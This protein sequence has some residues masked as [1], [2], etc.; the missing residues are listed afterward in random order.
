M[1]MKKLISFLCAAA[2]TVSSFAG[3]AVTASA[4]ADTVAITPT[5]GSKTV[6]VKKEGTTVTQGVLLHAVYA[7]GALTSVE[8]Q[9]IPATASAD[10]DV[11]YTKAA[12]AEYTSGTGS[13]FLAWKSLEGMEPITVNIVEPPAPKTQVNTVA[14]VAITRAQDDTYPATLTATVT[15]KQDA[16]FTDTTSFTYS[17]SKDGVAVNGGENGTLTA[18]TAGS[19]TVTATYNNSEGDFEG[20]ITSAPFSVED[21]TDTR[22]S[23]A[24][25]VTVT[26]T[27][28]ENNT[29]TPTTLTATVADVQDIATPT[30]L[31]ADDFTY[32]WTKDGETVD[33]ATTKTLEVAAGGA[34]EYKVVATVKSDNATYKGSTPQS[35][36]ITIKEPIV[37]DPYVSGTAPE[38]A[39]IRAVSVNVDDDSKA[40]T[41]K[42]LVEGEV[43]TT[44][45]TKDGADHNETYVKGALL[46]QKNS[47]GE[48]P[49]IVR[50]DK[51]DLDLT[52][53]KAY[54]KFTAKT[55][56][57]SSNL[58]L[59]TATAPSTDDIAALTGETKLATGTQLKKWGNTANTTDEVEITSLFDNDT[60]VVWFVINSESVRI[61][62]ITNLEFVVKAPHNVTVD[63]NITGGTITPDKATALQGETVTLTVTP[64]TGKEL[65]ADSLKVNN[66]AV[67]VEAVGVD[68]RFTM[69]DADATI[70]ATF[71]DET[72]PKYAVTLTGVPGY[73][74]VYTSTDGETYTTNPVART[75]HLGQIIQ[76]GDGTAAPSAVDATD[77]LIAR[78]PNGS[79]V[80]YKI[81][82][83]GYP[84]KTG[85]VTPN[86][87]AVAIDASSMAPTAAGV[88]YSENGD[89]NNANNASTM[90]GGTCRGDTARIRW[91]NSGA[92][93]TLN[94]D[95]L[96]ADKYALDFTISG[97]GTWQ[98]K[99]TT[100]TFKD[101]ADKTLATIKF[102]CTS[103][104]SS[105][106]WGKAQSAVLTVGSNSTTVTPSGSDT[107]FNAAKAIKLTVDKTTGTVTFKYGDDSV[108][109]TVD[110]AGMIKNIAMGGNNLQ[111]VTNLITVSTYTPVTPAA[112]TI[113]F[114]ASN[115]W[116]VKKGSSAIDSGAT[117]A[118][119][120]VITIEATAADKKVKSVTATGATFTVT[121]GV[122]SA[123]V[124]ATPADIVITAVELEDKTPATQATT[125]TITAVGADTDLNGKKLADL[126][127]SFTITGT[128]KAYTAKGTLKYVTGYTG[129][130]SNVAEQ[131]GNYLPFV[132]NVDDYN[133]NS[134]IKIKGN[135]AG[136]TE[137]TYTYADCNDGVFVFILGGQSTSLS[138]KVDRDGSGTAY[139]ETEYTLSWT[140]ATTA[141]EADKL[142]F[143]PATPTLSGTVTVKVDGEAAA[144]ATT[145]DT[146]T[147]DVTGVTASSGTPTLKYQW[148]KFNTAA[149]E[150]TITVGSFTGAWEDVDGKTAATYATPEVGIYRVVVSAD[151]YDGTVASGAVTVTQSMYRTY[152]FRTANNGYIDESNSYKT[153]NAELEQTRGSKDGQ[154]YDINGNG[155]V[156]FD[157]GSY[158]DNS[159]GVVVWGGENKITITAEGP[160]KITVGGC[161]Y[162]AATKVTLKAD[163]T[164]VDN[165][166]YLTDDS[167]P[168]A[169]TCWTGTDSETNSYVLKYAGSEAAT[170]TIV[171]DNYVYLPMLRIE[172]VTMV[173]V[174]AENASVAV[175]P[176]A[177]YTAGTALT[178]TATGTAETAAAEL[179][180]D[181]FDYKW[182]AGA[183]ATGTAL[184]E[185]AA[186][187]PTAAGKYT[188]EATANKFG[189]TGS[190]TTTVDV[191]AAPSKTDVTATVALSSTGDVVTATLS[192][193]DPAAAEGSFTYAWKKS[194]DNGT[195]W[196]D[197]EDVTSASITN[198]E[199]KAQYKVTASIPAGNET[200]AGS[201][202]S[203]AYTLDLT[204]S[205]KASETDLK[206]TAGHY[207]M[208]GL[209]TLFTDDA[210]KDLSATIEEENFT[211]YITCGTNGSWS[212][213]KAE[214]TALKYVAA[215]NGTFKIYVVNLNS[216]KELLITK[217]GTA[218][219]D[220]KTNTAGV[221]AYYKNEG[222][223]GSATLSLDVTKGETYYAYVAG[224]KANFV[225][226]KLD[227]DKYAVK[228]INPNDGEATPTDTA[229]ITLTDGVTN[230]LAAKDGKVTLTAVPVD[231]KA[232]TAVTV[233]KASGGTVEV[234]KEATAN[235]YSFTMPAEPV[236]VTATVA[237]TSA[238]APASITVSGAASVDANSTSTYTAAVYDAEGKVTSENGVT[239]TVY[240]DAGATTP[241]DKSEISDEGVLSV[242][243]DETAEALYIVATS[244]VSGS[245]GVK[246][247]AKAVT[248]NSV[249]VKQLVSFSRVT[250]EG[251]AVTSGYV[252]AAEDEAP[253]TGF[254][255]TAVTTI[256]AAQTGAAKLAAA[257]ADGKAELYLNPNKTY[258]LTLKTAEDGDVIATNIAYAPTVAAETTAVNKAVAAASVPEKDALTAAG[259]TSITP[260]NAIVGDEVT[261]TIPA[262]DTGVTI[263]GVKVNGTIDAEKVTDTTYKVTIPAGGI[264]DIVISKT[265]Q[266]YATISTF[267]DE[268]LGKQQSD[269]NSGL[270][271]TLDAEKANTYN[272]TGTLKYVS[273]WTEFD[274]KNTELQSG[275][276]IS[277]QVVIP[278][279]TA[280]STISV[281]GNAQGSTPINV[282]KASEDFVIHLGSQSTALIVTVDKDGA[283]G[284]N[285][286][287][288]EYTIDI[289]KLVKNP[290]P[291]ASSATVTTSTSETPWKGHSPNELGT[292]TVQST[293]QEGYDYELVGTANYIADY[294][295]AFGTEDG[296][297][298][299]KGYYIPFSIDIPSTVADP[300][301]AVLTYKSSAATKTYTYDSFTTEDRN[302]TV[303]L[304]LNP[305]ATYFTYTIDWDG[306]GEAFTAK[307]YK[308]YIDQSGTS[309]ETETKL[310]KAPQPVTNYTITLPTGLTGGSVAVTT[311]DNYNATTGVAEGTDVVITA[312]PSEGYQLKT[313]TV[314]NGDETVTDT[315]SDNTTYTFTMPAGNVSVSAEFEQLFAITKSAMTN[316]GV[317]VY[318]VTENSGT[319]TKA[320]AEIADLTKVADGTKI[321]VEANPDDGYALSGDI[322]VV[323]T[324]TASD[325]TPTAATSETL[326]VS[327]VADTTVYTV[328]AALTISAA[329]EWNVLD[330]DY[331]AYSTAAITTTTANGQDIAVA[332][333]DKWK[334]VSH[335]SAFPSWQ[336][337]EG[338]GVIFKA[339]SAN[340]KSRPYTVKKAFSDTINTGKV[341]VHAEGGIANW[342][343]GET[344]TGNRGNF[345]G[346]VDS[347]GKDVI[348]IGFNRSGVQTYLNGVW[349]SY[350]GTKENLDLGSMTIDLTVDFDLG[351][352]TYRVYNVGK[353]ATALEGSISIDKTTANAA[354]IVL[355][356]LGILED[357][358]T[359]TV[360]ELKAMHQTPETTATT[361][362]IKSVDNG[363]S[364][365]VLGE[366][367]NQAGY[368]GEWIRID[369]A[370]KTFNSKKYKY[371][372]DDSATK[373]L[374]S[375]A[376][377]N[378]ITIKYNPYST[379]TFTATLNSAA[380]SGVPIVISTADE[381]EQGA[382]QTYTT[383]DTITTGADGTASKELLAG[384][385]YYSI[386][387][388]TD[389]EAVANAESTKVIVSN[390][391]T[392]V[393]VAVALAEK[394]DPTYNVTI[395]T[396]PYAT[397][398]IGALTTPKGTEVAAKTKKADRKGVVKF[399]S[400]DMLPAASYTVTLTSDNGYFAAKANQTMT[401]TSEATTF[402]YPFEYDT[403]TYPNLIY[404]ED[405][406]Y[407][408]KTE[409]V[410]F[411]E[412]A[413]I[414]SLTN[415]NYS[416]IYASA[417]GASGYG[418]NVTQIA[419]NNN[420][421]YY[422]AGYNSDNHEVKFNPNQ[423]I[424]KATFDYAIGAQTWAGG[425][426]SARG[427]AAQTLEFGNLIITLTPASTSAQSDTT[428]G[429]D[430]TI[431]IT[432]GTT[433][434][435]ATSKVKQLAWAKYSI[436]VA[437]DKSVTV[438]VTPRGG[439]V[440]SI[441]GFT[442]TKDVTAFSFKG[443]RSASFAIDN[444]E[445][446]GAAE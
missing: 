161:Q 256:P 428:L 14:D 245:E 214:G 278:E 345:F 227:V 215:A 274:G 231:G 101:A 303:I 198:A 260:A 237:S 403:T 136:S 376:E 116:T 194:T 52:G 167:T 118:A 140:K 65:Q 251:S 13:K 289:S 178:A 95:S 446:Y 325:Q 272:A 117:L 442:L 281:V 240:T 439:T 262:A 217:A 242:G 53:K 91:Q 250:D 2:L 348:T 124:G 103:Y 7:N 30:G 386:A 253:N 158:Y 394:G 313:L 129:F 148:Q 444:I 329:F 212:E 437:G 324:A 28:A 284:T 113:T 435:S 64:A 368:V 292:F 220:I 332:T 102:A 426:P 81:T 43:K 163:G 59:S 72:T 347:A 73:A 243:A 261:I 96:T 160:T 184:A 309:A 82:K 216:Q 23:V 69:P 218:T 108:S 4:A 110:G 362:T 283:E 391:G 155:T 264:N 267:A 196:T 174:N 122:A 27:A 47:K 15:A 238:G 153:D 169:G 305:A 11:T 55:N 392:A 326:T 70:T 430:C 343:T 76:L 94:T 79:A 420:F 36:G 49:V 269:L 255:T 389:Y 183:E 179:T 68:Y 146:L 107:S 351:I 254:F 145:D 206:K 46:A 406:A 417:G 310:Y 424:T 50:I 340:N 268:Q 20:T 186:Y 83:A 441:T 10:A 342:I 149:T 141:D 199:A 363:N 226:A 431:S 276:Y 18:A 298:M 397:V 173:P 322:A 61:Q 24:D 370:D 133:E 308:V 42:E 60:S 5:V 407:D 115:D 438:K 405:F 85:S 97:W 157:K 422:T 229:T 135:A 66:G 413:G 279:G 38:G 346:I 137:N 219:S 208:N 401:V 162:S 221:T 19:Y 295:G 56:F 92:V 409:V 415:N 152:D 159:H 175:T 434:N 191:A 357:G 436:E 331:T 387:E 187:T 22:T 57:G 384:T 143:T 87:A 293:T 74:Q 285:Y 58:T 252:V 412:T 8:S 275:N 319:Y 291:Q 62:N 228:A 411:N 433:T 314:K 33:G 246:S 86:G 390:T 114:T 188:V 366:V 166:T 282:T 299:T 353:T 211:H 100:Y 223:K 99:E 202:T 380:K 77:I 354:G 323:T 400:D 423:K 321:V 98:A 379:V 204:N 29:K 315:D 349:S 432:D 236:T 445:I 312:T 378:I 273:G 130:S 185:T 369:T 398:S 355:G 350:S 105:A 209:S 297:D 287:P 197:I 35:A 75:N 443:N 233:T 360:S 427:T 26:I 54:I 176:A 171:F 44:E 302:C 425:T 244:S 84:D 247:T 177:P 393:P 277:F 241:A 316:G 294:T 361:Y 51:G 304:F 410:N 402:N 128:D 296:V 109:G 259:V 385:Y 395:N 120:D 358:N 90:G 32:V 80:Y 377:N 373:L 131:S 170:L 21:P 63:S 248:V 127:D 301:K 37:G 335:T 414:I 67:T 224:S 45:N 31:T 104:S 3:L 138:I 207:L 106:D 418:G 203:D 93:V 263:T 40:L 330:I 290:A 265:T 334:L 416:H 111:M 9:N 249:Y 381:V 134:T 356:E 404:G 39:T 201:A 382:E 119:N 189:F 257:I 1:K 306:E 408:D 320:S 139:E 41:Y 388:G 12:Y 374:T 123:N 429:D 151:D 168:T 383:V 172:K 210:G 164:E 337:T 147:A 239:W 89:W 344:A 213:G 48:S 182:Y 225:G 181:D 372:S 25:L 318:E 338:T 230:G 16:Q 365:A 396:S 421:G 271:I 125:A 339:G 195:T 17:W 78:Q 154:N 234:T 6:T 327:G 367:S 126:T 317:K 300:T 180:A 192:E 232:V 371:V 88:L 132:V 190:V 364:D 222:E 235:T 288:T 258:K 144:E 34:G 352:A 341:T 307:T 266:T 328:D 359:F 205:W 336:T 440:E 311:P 333:D 121:D 375:T 193:V 200:Y 286:A 112:K 270:T 142:Y 156:V 419:E 280:A 150:N 399:E 71:I 165:A